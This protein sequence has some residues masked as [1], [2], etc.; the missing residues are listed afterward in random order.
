MALYIHLLLYSNYIRRKLTW[1]WNS[2]SDLSERYQIDENIRALH[3]IIRFLWLHIIF[4]CT[5]G[6]V[7]FITIVVRFLFYQYLVRQFFHDSLLFSVGWFKIILKVIFKL[8]VAH[9]K[10]SD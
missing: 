1:Q 5:A 7:A 6:T 2:E 4:N 10:I 8:I 9:I 3:F